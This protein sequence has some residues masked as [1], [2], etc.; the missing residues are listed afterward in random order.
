[1]HGDQTA[2]PVPLLLQKLKSQEEDIA[3]ALSRLSDGNDNDGVTAAVQRLID[4]Y[5]RTIAEDASHALPAYDVRQAVERCKQ[6]RARVVSIK[7]GSGGGGSV[8]RRR[9]RYGLGDNNNNN[10]ASSSS[11]SKKKKKQKGRENIVEEEEEGDAEPGEEGRPPPHHMVVVRGVRHCTL[12]PSADA[13]GE[14]QKKWQSCTST[15]CTT[16]RCSSRERDDIHH[17]QV[18]IHN[19]SNCTFPLLPQTVQ[20][21]TGGMHGARLPVSSP[22]EEETRILVEDFGWLRRDAPSPNFTITHAE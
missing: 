17:H 7:K 21:H 19:S 13:A 12:Y 1:M 14:N 9:F 2:Q 6:F 22:E 4:V 5:E 20:H 11:S 15:M 10:G 16:A 18:R 3:N 8:R